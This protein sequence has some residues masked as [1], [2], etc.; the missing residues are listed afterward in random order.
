MKNTKRKIL[1]FIFMFFFT[2][3]V[4][5]ASERSVIPLGKV[6]GVRLYTDGLLIVG[7]GEV[8]GINVSKKY[9]LRV[10]DLIKGV[11]NKT[12]KTPEELIKE[13]NNSPNGVT[14]SIERDN[15]TILVNAVP[16]LSD[17]DSYRIGVWVRDSSAGI[18]TLT[19]INPENN[20][21]ACLGH[22]IN[23]VD[24]G[25]ILSVSTGNIL[26][27]NILSI[28]KSS[29]SNPGKINGSFDSNDIIGEIKSNTKMGVYGN[30]SNYDFSQISP[31]PVATKDE[32]QTGEAYIISDILG[33]K[34]EC[35]SAQI[36]K[37]KNSDD[38]SIVVTI[39]DERLI[40][41]TGGIVQG[42]SGSPIIQNNKIVG[43][44]THV[45]VNNTLKGYGICIENMLAEE[46]NI[47]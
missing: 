7:T 44:I 46:K 28:R 47:S 13:I 11:N 34:N 38:K 18:G 17:D 37:I 25:N 33:S 6:V 12:V 24:T 42:M 29:R 4:A 45:F 32:I 36:T 21:F 9:G 31:M 27:C 8:N 20:S 14:L 39:T 10:N 23:D 35:Y 15:Q 16:V 41:N 3:T 5:D 26:N 19:Y 22:A 1:T 30:V 43:A 2:F 40:E